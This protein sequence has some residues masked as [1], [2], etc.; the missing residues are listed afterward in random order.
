MKGHLRWRKGEAEEDKTEKRPSRNEVR[1]VC[2]IREDTKLTMLKSAT[3]FAR[4][5]IWQ[6]VSL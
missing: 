2:G 5:G 6:E 1:G 4:L 3:C